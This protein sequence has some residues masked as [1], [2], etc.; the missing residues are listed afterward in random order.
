MTL[1]SVFHQVVFAI[2]TRVIH[3][4]GPLELDSLLGHRELTLKNRLELVRMALLQ[5]VFV[6]PIKV[7]LLMIADDLRVT[8]L[9]LTMILM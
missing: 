4:L 8:N 7:S 6:M 3:A 1:W 5:V 9:A 2:V